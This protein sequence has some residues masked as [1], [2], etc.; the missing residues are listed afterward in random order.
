MF[1]DTFL[2]RGYWYTKQLFNPV[3]SNPYLHP[4]GTEEAN[5]FNKTMKGTSN[6]SG[7]EV[8]TM[9]AISYSGKKG[10]TAP[11][12]ISF[13]LILAG[14]VDNSG[15]LVQQSQLCLRHTM[16]HMAGR[17]QAPQLPA[18]MAFAYILTHKDN[19][20]VIFFLLLKCKHI[21]L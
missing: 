20:F 10:Q 7:C 13:L 12:C 11:R 18:E 15:P 8:F 16:E 21:C 6:R 3:I 4:F 5:S 19:I 9:G 17:M 1:L 2:V 14:A